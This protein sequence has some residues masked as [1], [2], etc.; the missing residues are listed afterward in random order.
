MTAFA[1]AMAVLF[2]DRNMAVDAVLTPG[3]TGTPLSLRAMRRRPDEVEDWGRSQIQSPT[4]VLD[5]RVADA[6]D[7]ARGDRID[8]GGDALRVRSL[9]RRDREG[10]VWTVEMEPW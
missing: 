2:A 8:I 3:G 7:L 4:A 9:P 6:P 10:L 5:I 1:T